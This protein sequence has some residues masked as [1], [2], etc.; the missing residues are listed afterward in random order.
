MP[1]KERR[2]RKSGRVAQLEIMHFGGWEEWGLW[3]ELL[4]RQAGTAANGAV[5]QENNLPGQRSQVFEY[6]FHHD[7]FD[8]F[9]ALLNCKRARVMRSRRPPFF[10]KSSSSLRSCWS[11]K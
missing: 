8:V 3:E 2:T 5:M 9:L 1:A 6:C 11:I 4:Q 7:S 10:T